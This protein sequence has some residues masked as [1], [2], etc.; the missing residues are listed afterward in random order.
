M[1]AAR[2]FQHP[3]AVREGAHA[4]RARRDRHRLLHQHPFHRRRADSSHTG[5]QAMR[6][7]HALPRPA[8]ICNRP[9][10]G[11]ARNANQVDAHRY[12]VLA[13]VAIVIAIGECAQ[14][15]V[16]GPIVADLAT[17]APARPLHVALRLSF[18]AGVAL[19]PRPAAR[20]SQPHPT[21]IW[22][23]GALT[24]ALTGAGLLRLR[25]RIPDPLLQAQCPP[26]QAVSAADT[27]PA[28]HSQMNSTK[29]ECH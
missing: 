13:G 19:G 27:D 26:P 25:H 9:A 10:R 1:T 24:A 20:C 15:I 17:A 8:P 4:C 22:W 6:R 2:S 3:R 21:P 18:T 12:R 7:T 14:F 29:M 28:S 23:G 5:R 16:L 11:P